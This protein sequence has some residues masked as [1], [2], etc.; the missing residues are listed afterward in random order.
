MTNYSLRSRGS[1]ANSYILP[2]AHRAH[3][4][5]LL[6]RETVDAP[7]YLAERPIPSLTAV[8][9]SRAPFP[10][11]SVLSDENIGLYVLINPSAQ[12][13]RHDSSGLKGCT[14]CKLSAS[15]LKV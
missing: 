10:S 3:L 15:R 1:R 14:D 11:L 4:R 7:L 8:L 2:R 5:N 12:V 13:R 6:R 9:H